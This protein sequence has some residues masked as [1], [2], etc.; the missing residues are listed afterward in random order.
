MSHTQAEKKRLSN[1][2]RRIL[3]QVAAIQRAVDEG[4]ECALLLHTIAACRGAM[5]G[6]M[7]EVIESHIRFHVLGPDGKATREQVRAADD[8]VRALRAYLK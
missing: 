6:L 2:V 7:A 3:G 4:A 8:L 1:R 5:D